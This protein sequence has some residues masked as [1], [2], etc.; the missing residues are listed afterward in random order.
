[1]IITL[2]FETYY[3][4]EYSLSK[5]SEVDYI[6]SPLF[7]TICC[8]V[9]IDDENPYAAYGHDDVARA[10]SELPWSKAAL[11]SHNTRFDGAI[12][13]WIF[14]LMPG[15]YLDTLSMARA[16]T[17][18]VLG[19][20]SLEKV[21]EY[22]K[23]PPKGKEVIAAFG[24][25]LEDFMPNEL[26]QYGA[27]SCHDANLSKWIFNHFMRVFPQSELRVID[28]FLRMFIEPQAKLNPHK[29]AHNLMAVRAEK[30]RTFQR[31]A[32]IDKSVF[33]SQPQFAALLESHGVDVPTKISATTG[34]E[35]PALA[36]NDR[37]FKEL[38]ADDTLTPDVQALLAARISAK[39]TIEE[40]R[41]VTLLNLSQR[42]WGARGAGWMPVPLRYYGAHTGRPS[43]DGGF[44]FTNL[45][46]GSPI[47]DAI[48][49]PEGMRVVHRDSSQI[50]ARMV[51]FLSGCWTLLE[52][53]AQGRDIYSEFATEFYGCAITKADKPRRFVGKTCILG[54]GYGMGA[55]R[56]RHTL[57]IGAG[58][59]SV[60]VTEE[61]AAVLVK[62][63]RN[64]YSEIPWLWK[65]AARMAEQIIL[66]SGRRWNP[67]LVG[68]D[69]ETAIP[70]V[71]VGHDSIILPNNMRI[72]YPEIRHQTIN[73]PAGI[74]TQLGFARGTGFKKL[75]GGSIVENISQALARIVITDAMIRIY[76]ET[77]YHPTLTTYDSLD[78]I[79]PVEDA[80]AMDLILAREFAV[81][82][83]WAPNLPLAS[84]GGFGRTLLIAE[85]ENSPEHNL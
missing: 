39:S 57:F 60:K 42:E 65:R 56:L 54:L 32:Y 24:K 36:K 62:L 14:G 48:E 12:L 5:I 75:F 55:P 78:Y 29:L 52:A 23:L 33:S 77:G 41:S 76:A 72:C 17:H 45:R 1:M 27:Y 43:G 61:E 69:G 74:E 51:A 30:E 18:P 37:A 19:R 26:A 4:K 6:L 64:L 38:C 82:P 11:L 40:T 35:I 66:L 46:R 20:S 53:F 8:A 44:N 22:L 71:R 67:K 83:S 31:V 68:H 73:T 3:A 58:G 25:R 34:M 81:R 49:A 47:R 80:P 9:K 59:V 70:A 2:D 84:E 7:Q 63:Y 13:A 21:A 50:E 28:L 85:D 15:F 79:V 16:L 10:L